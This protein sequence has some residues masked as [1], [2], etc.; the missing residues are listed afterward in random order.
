MEL[1]NPR[2]FIPAV[3]LMLLLIVVASC[4]AEYTNEAIA[5]AIFKAENSL[6][7]PYGILT[8]YKTTTPRQACLNTIIHARKDW[9]GQCDFIEFLGSR[10]CPIG[11]KNDPTG[12]NKN[13][14]R[15]VKYFLKGGK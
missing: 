4:R 8:H 11:A 6:N 15:N 10:Y 3:M 1:P 2:Y 13:W 7:H 9:N 12:L 14:V 5:D